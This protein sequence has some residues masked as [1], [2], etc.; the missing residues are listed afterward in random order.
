MGPWTQIVNLYLKMSEEYDIQKEVVESDLNKF[1]KI[2]DKVAANP[3]FYYANSTED[4]FQDMRKML[5]KA[6]RELALLEKETLGARDPT[7]REKCE[8]EYS[9]LKKLHEGYRA[10]LNNLEIQARDAAVNSGAVQEDPLTAEQ[11][12]GAAVVIQE[13]TNVRV[14]DTI[15][16]M[17]EVVVM[18]DAILESLDRDM[19]RLNRVSDEL[20]GIQADAAL[21]R[22]QLRNVIR[23]LAS[24]KRLL[25]IMMVICVIML[26]LSITDL[27][28]SLNRK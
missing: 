17:Q 21:A 7:V 27:A 1:K 19:E 23:A 3:A 10:N 12:L 20:D 14:K 11:R 18:N 22:R 6:G 4:V 26:I 24:N 8:V 5:A 15:N 25:C 9:N 13:D 28:S 16:I 2:Y